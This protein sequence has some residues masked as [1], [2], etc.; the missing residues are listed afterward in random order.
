MALDLFYQ[1]SNMNLSLTDCVESRPKP[2]CYFLVLQAFKSSE[3]EVLN[4]LASV[5]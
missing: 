1:S 2:S 5:L 3:P 4:P